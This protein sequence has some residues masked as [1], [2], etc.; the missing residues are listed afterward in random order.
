MTHMR[1]WKSHRLTSHAWLGLNL[2]KGLSVL[3]G[4]FLF[5]FSKNIKENGASL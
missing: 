1:S 4:Y 3:L 2:Q 5:L